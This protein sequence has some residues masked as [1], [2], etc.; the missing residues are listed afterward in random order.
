MACLDECGTSIADDLLDA[1]ERVR[2]ESRINRKRIQLDPDLMMI[3]S[4]RDA[5]PDTDEEDETRRGA[6]AQGSDQE[7]KK[8]SA[9]ASILLFDSWNTDDKS[10]TSAAERSQNSSWKGE[11]GLCA[12]ARRNWWRQGCWS[13]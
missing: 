8:V 13:E 2:Q 5:G 3:L 11:V 7:R 1:D 4:S 10:C 6:L 9:R 12:R